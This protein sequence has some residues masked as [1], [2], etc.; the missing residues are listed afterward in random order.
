MLT[1]TPLPIQSRAS[2][3]GPPRVT[4]IAPASP[5]PPAAS[6]A[7][8]T[9]ASCAARRAPSTTRAPAAARIRAKC[10]PRPEEAPVTRAILPSSGGTGGLALDLLGEAP[11]VDLGRSV[12]DPEGADFTEDL[13]DDRVAGDA[14][15]AHD[16]NAAVGDAEQ[17]FGHRDLG[18]RA[19]GRAQ[20]A[21]IEHARAPADHQFRLL[22]IDEIVG[23]HE[24]DPLMI[25]Q[26]FSEGLA[27][28][29]IG[30]R[31]L[32]G[33]GFMLAD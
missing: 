27:A 3:P 30:G 24:A 5:R 33:V 22:Q 16:L 20:R 18:H 23:E 13:L 10:A 25:D 14:G 32:E 6:I 19:F 12:I 15:A 26:R 2:V 4:S 31:D 7:R 9:S 1:F 8:T 17:G 21:G 11:F 28:A 29:R